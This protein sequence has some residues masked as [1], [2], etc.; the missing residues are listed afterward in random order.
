MNESVE[1]EAERRYDDWDGLERFNLI[2]G[3]VLRERD[4]AR[5]AASLK[6]LMDVIPQDVIV[7]NE[8]EINSAWS[9]AK[10]ALYLHEVQQ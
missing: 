2:E 4:S 8:D 3:I 9:D 6:K 1:Q 10:H 7:D 5:L